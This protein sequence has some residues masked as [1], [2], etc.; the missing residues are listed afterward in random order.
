[1][2]KKIVGWLL[3]GLP[4]LIFV[5]ALLMITTLEEFITIVVLVSGGLFLVWCI[6]KGAELVDE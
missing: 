1:M 2:K 6:F 3:V 4:M 5:L